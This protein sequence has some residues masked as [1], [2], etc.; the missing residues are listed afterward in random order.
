[1]DDLDLD[2]DD[3]ILFL[4]PHKG[5]GF[6]GAAFATDL[7]ENNQTT[8]HPST[9]ERGGTE[10]PDEYGLLENTDCL[11]LRFSH[12]S[13]TSIGVVGGCAENAELAIQDIPGVSKF[14][15]AFT[16][17]DRN[18]PIARDLGSK[19]GTKVTYNGE[20][21]ERLSDFDWPLIG[22]SITKGRYPILNI[23][24]LVQF[25][26]IMPCRD[27]MSPDYIE[28]V[29]QFR[30][31]TGDPENLF[32]S[33]IIRSAQGTRLPTGQQTPP[34]GPR[35]GPILYKE[36]LGKGSFGVVMY[37]WNVATRD[38][39]V[40]KKPRQKLI[41]TGKVSM[42]SWTNE[43]NIMRSI[44]HEHI[45]VFRDATFD[46]YPQLEFEYMPGGSLDKYT[47][48]SAVEST[49][50]LCQLSSALEY[51]HN[52]KPSIGHRDIKPENVLV[53][54][55]TVNGI[56]VK[57]GDFGLSKAADVL[58]T[59]CGTT[60]YAAP[61]IHLKMARVKGAANNTYDVAVDIWSL[62]VLGVFLLCG[63]LPVHKNEW[64]GDAFAW[65]HAVVNHVVEVY[66]RQDGEILWLIIDSMLVEDPEE[67]SS[68]DYVHDEAVKIL[69]SM[70]NNKPN[71]DDDD[72]GG[73]GSTTP[74]PSSMPTAQ[75]AVGS[76]DDTEEAST[77][78][79]VI[80]PALD[81]PSMSIRE[82]VEGLYEE[83]LMENHS[84]ATS[85][86]DSEE[87]ER[88]RLDAP[89]P[90]TQLS[91][92]PEGARP[93]SLGSTVNG[94]LWDPADS[95]MA[96]LTSNH[97]NE[98][99]E[100]NTGEH[101][102]GDNVSFLVQFEEVQGEGAGAVDAPGGRQPMRKRTRPE[103]RSSSS[104]SLP[105]SYT[106]PFSSVEQRG[107][108]SPAPKRSKIEEERGARP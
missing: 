10:L 94:L 71:N 86:T 75:P 89:S 65:I 84:H 9:R 7:L 15:L 2:L 28:K 97:G 104:L 11:V 66:E 79:L 102:E 64:I 43:F 56:R 73:D 1:M 91:L 29:K 34:T 88:E 49:Q 18:M 12:G 16:F 70:V 23:T 77:F 85:T 13:R 99:S 100:F 24:D 105:R 32:A 60:L 101:D 62:G 96:S 30:V 45:V 17:D 3:V 108:R 103:K 63:G 83:S 38:E 51:P 53:S 57:F 6:E 26:V 81:G 47:D 106:H 98:A 20:P 55:R 33:L 42:E 76:E 50:I 41:D 21:G 19:G 67:R 74:R 82:T 35:S 69:Q 44:S 90:E 27:F 61:E 95:A 87:E 93:L 37:V 78:R 5:E 4:L 92:A 46:P 59:C 22:P 107:T 58:K 52:Q 25:Q 31:G 36:R 68:A 8:Q 48:L 80:Q 40:V 54:E 14:H 39:Y 72:D